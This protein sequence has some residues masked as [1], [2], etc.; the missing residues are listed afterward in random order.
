MTRLTF[1]LTFLL[2]LFVGWGSSVLHPAP[3]EP[4]A[5]PA[6]ASLSAPIEPTHEQ[7]SENAAV[8]SKAAAPAPMEVQAE[9][10]RHPVSSLEG[11]PLRLLTLAMMVADWAKEDFDGAI[12]W[13]DRTDLGDQKGFC[14]SM[15]LLGLAEIDPARSLDEGIAM[16]RNDTLEIINPSTLMKICLREQPNRIEELLDLPKHGGHTKSPAVEFGP[17]TD[18]RKIG[19]LV[20]RKYRESGEDGWSPAAFPQDFLTEWTKIDPQGAYDFCF[21]QLD[22]HFKSVTSDAVEE[23]ATTYALVAAPEEA[24]E[25][26]RELLTADELK[27]SREGISRSFQK[28]GEAEFRVFMKAVE[29]LP[30]EIRDKIGFESVGEYPFSNSLAAAEE[31]GRALRVITTPSVRVAAVRGLIEKNPKLADGLRAQL[32]SLGHS[33]DEIKLAM[34]PM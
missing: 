25:L 8:P 4:R 9:R 22:V 32:K 12:R 15:A 31:R 13:L 33:E 21:D 16:Y 2:G 29:T 17:T 18:F 1:M 23:F 30:A 10:L 6:S 5:T 34:S 3:P 14:V 24:A 20:L 11:D 7:P 28:A 27:E 19:E 26:L